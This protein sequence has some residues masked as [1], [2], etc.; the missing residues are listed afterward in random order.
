MVEE[1]KCSVMD[2]RVA[3]IALE[4]KYLFY[5]LCYHYRYHGDYNMQLQTFIVDAH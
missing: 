5:Y 2:D 3:G 1:Y 4:N